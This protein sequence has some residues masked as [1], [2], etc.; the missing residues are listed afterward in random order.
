MSMTCLCFSSSL[1]IVPLLK[2]FSPPVFYFLVGGEALLE[3]VAEG[4]SYDVYFVIVT[5]ELMRPSTPNEG[6]LNFII[7]LRLSL[8]FNFLSY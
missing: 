3:K 1:A 4:N 5:G 7:I 6:D 8:A 2:F